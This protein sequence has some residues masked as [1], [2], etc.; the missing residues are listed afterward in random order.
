MACDGLADSAR[1]DALTCSPAC[2][3]WLHRHPARLAQVQRIGKRFDLTPAQMQYG[4]AMARLVPD[5]WAQMARGVT[6]A[7]IRDAVRAV[8]F[9]ILLAA[10]RDAKAAA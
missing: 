8:Y 10:T 2:R 6:E 1:S 4:A 7:A 9:D 5:A 3:T